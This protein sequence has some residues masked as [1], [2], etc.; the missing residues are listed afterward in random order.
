MTDTIE[1]IRK[2]RGCSTCF[3]RDKKWHESPCRFAE[4]GKCMA[5]RKK[6]DDI[7]DRATSTPQ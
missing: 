6:D 2:V 7:S 1:H 4:N 3:Y 5:W